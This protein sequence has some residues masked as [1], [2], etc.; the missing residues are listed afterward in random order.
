MPTSLEFLFAVRRSSQGVS[1]LNRVLAHLPG[2]RHV[3]CCTRK[4]RTLCEADHN[5]WNCLV[6]AVNDRAAEFLGPLLISASQLSHSTS[7]IHVF[8]VTGALRALAPESA[9]E[10]V[11]THFCRGRI[12]ACCLPNRPRE[13]LLTFPLRPRRQYVISG[14]RS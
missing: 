2:T 14:R 6:D 13:L 3:V 8:V 12:K 9:F 10:D 1:A 11:G 4:G 5:P 7:A